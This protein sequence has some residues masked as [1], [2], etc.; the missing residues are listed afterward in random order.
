MARYLAKQIYKGKMDYD[1]VI[2]TYPEYKDQI[3]EVLKDLGWE[4]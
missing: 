2:A 1:E 4:G 3:D